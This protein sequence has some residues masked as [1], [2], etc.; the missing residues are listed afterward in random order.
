ME[1]KNGIYKDYNL[2]TEEGKLLIKAIVI[3]STSKFN[4]LGNVING[5]EKTQEDIIEL[6]EKFPNI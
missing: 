1:I 2:E 6:L 5:C 3:L 4:Y